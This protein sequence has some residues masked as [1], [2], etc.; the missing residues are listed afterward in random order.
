MV[1]GM[2]IKSLEEIDLFSL[3]IREAEIIDFF[4]RASIKDKILKIIPVQ[5]KTHIG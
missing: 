1:K 3:P 4:L 2:K 5:M